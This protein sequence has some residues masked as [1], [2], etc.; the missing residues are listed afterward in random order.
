[1]DSKYTDITNYATCS[2]DMDYAEK[3]MYIN[4][5]QII[6]YEM[7]HLQNKKVNYSIQ[8]TLKYNWINN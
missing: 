2:D 7:Y 8:S 6:M 5:M 4:I 3:N 1:M